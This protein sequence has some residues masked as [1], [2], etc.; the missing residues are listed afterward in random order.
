MA[1]LIPLSCKKYHSRKA[2]ESYERGKCEDGDGEAQFIS[3][4]PDSHLNWCHQRRAVT[5][6]TEKQ[7][8]T[9][10][11]QFPIAVTVWGNA[12]LPARMNFIGLWIQM[13][14]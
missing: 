6:V 14:K 8:K 1:Q 9:K 3:G 4:S 12:H 13:T 7:N 10:L 2:N 5:R 11:Q